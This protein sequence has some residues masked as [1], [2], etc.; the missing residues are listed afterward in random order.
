MVF[1]GL[2]KDMSA[3]IPEEKLSRGPDKPRRSLFC[4]PVLCYL[5]FKHSN[6]PMFIYFMDNPKKLALF[7]IA[8]HKKLDEGD[9]AVNTN[10]GTWIKWIWRGKIT[11]SEIQK[12]RQKLAEIHKKADED[13]IK[14]KNS[15]KNFVNQEYLE[16]NAENLD[17]YEK[18]VSYKNAF[19]RS[20][21]GILNKNAVPSLDEESTIDDLTRYFV[22]TRDE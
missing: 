6:D 20:T 5:R 14:T 8:H 7:L 15:G 1:I 10:A 12:V 16:S 9:Y 17:I 2:I 13:K 11:N 18:G 22:E 19:S 3:S 4:K 21:S